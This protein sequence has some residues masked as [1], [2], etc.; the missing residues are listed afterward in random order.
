MGLKKSYSKCFC[1][2]IW[3]TIKGLLLDKRMVGPTNI[4]EILLKGIVDS[5]PA[6]AI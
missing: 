5:C 6:M 1:F 2:I 3:Y 4:R